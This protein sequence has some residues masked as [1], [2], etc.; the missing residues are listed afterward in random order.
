[1]IGVGPGRDE[2]V[3]DPRPDLIETRIAAECAARRVPRSRERTR[4]SCQ[5]EAAPALAVRTPDER[6]SQQLADGADGVVG[7]VGDQAVDARAR[8]A[9]GPR[10]ARRPG[11]GGVADPQVLGQERVL[12]AQRPAED[13][14][15][16]AVRLVDQRR[17]PAPP[18]G[19]EDA[20]AAGADALRVGR[21]L[22]Q[23]RRG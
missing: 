17:R 2:N 16:G 22:A 5:R 11:L 18:L 3:V 23:A 9:D 7:G 19:A 10:R 8:A 15:R 6:R 1:M 12:G 13:R 4:S 21:D 14:Q 20:L